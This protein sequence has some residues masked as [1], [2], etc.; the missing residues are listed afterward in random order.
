MRLCQSRL[1][2][3]E[4]IFNYINGFFDDVYYIQDVREL[5]RHTAKVQKFALKI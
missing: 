5:K 1:T 3:D 2:L 4:I